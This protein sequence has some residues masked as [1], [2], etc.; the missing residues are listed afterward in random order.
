[1]LSTLPL[2][3]NP[4]FGSTFVFAMALANIW[5]IFAA[6]WDILS[7]YTGYISFG[8]SALS[9][10][11]AYT[12]A[13]ILFNIDPGMS[14][15]ITFPLSV[16][17]ALIV[18][19]LFAFPALRLKGP[20]FSLIT[21]LSVLI[22]IRLVFILSDYTRGELGIGEVPIISFDY[23][24]VYY[25]TFLPMIL[26]VSVLFYISRSDIGNVFVAIRENE[27]AVE[28][29][30]LDTTKFKLWA[31]TLS[32]IP[33]GIGGTLLAHFY[34]NVDPATVL[35]V[36]RSIEMVMMAIIG[37][38][39]TILGPVVGAYIFILLRDIV[40][41]S[42][43]GSTERWIAL[44]SVVLVILVVANDGIVYRLWNKI[45]ELGG[46]KE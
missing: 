40:F 36:E 34:G 15:L 43:L 19:L 45:G 33:M 21:L 31:F 5:A 7:G 30:G 1:M 4:I 24:M 37:G 23:T 41:T 12:T 28:A 9:G 35:E 8:H 27:Y 11:A 44:W 13:L 32:A 6:S 10:V 42:F 22:L 2:W 25:V 14:I 39:G 17:F 29:A 20:Y 46:E 38:T 18:G 16:L 26:I 3:G